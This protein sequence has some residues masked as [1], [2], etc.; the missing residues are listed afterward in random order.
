MLCTYPVSLCTCKLENTRKMCV[1]EDE[2]ADGRAGECTRGMLLE[3][4]FCRLRAF[5]YLAGELIKT[6]FFCQFIFLRM[7][8]DCG[9]ICSNSVVSGLRDLTCSTRVTAV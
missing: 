1:K 9:R 2:G 7:K 6:P 8:L 3:L 4:M 5:Q